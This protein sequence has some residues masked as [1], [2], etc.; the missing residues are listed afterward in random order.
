VGGQ[1]VVEPSRA[2]RNPSRPRRGSA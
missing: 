2:R 1:N